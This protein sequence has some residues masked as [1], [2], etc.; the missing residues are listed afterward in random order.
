MSCT[1][2]A[3]IWPLVLVVLIAVCAWVA[4]A[5]WMLW[6]VAKRRKRRVEWL[7]CPDRGCWLKYKG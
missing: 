6:P 4:L 7:S 2:T 3:C 5:A 1:E